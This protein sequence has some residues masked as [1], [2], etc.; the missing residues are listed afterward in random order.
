MPADQ[1]TETR[2]SLQDQLLWRPVQVH[3]KHQQVSGGFL[4]NYVYMGTDCISIKEAVSFI[5]VA[6]NMCCPLRPQK[7]SL[8]DFFFLKFSN[9]HLC[10][11][12]V[13]VLFSP[14]KG[15][16]NYFIIGNRHLTNSSSRLG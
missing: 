16:R 6:N 12:L 15:I 7:V 13:E 4:N 14:M 1:Q 8:F 9:I 2:I 5:Y 3:G 10:M 11:Y